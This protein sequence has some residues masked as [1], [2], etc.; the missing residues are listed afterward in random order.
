MDLTEAAKHYGIKQI[1]FH[2][3]G[4]AIG[5]GGGHALNQAILGAASQRPC[6]KGRIKITEQGEMIHS[7]YGNP[8]LAER[9]LELVLSAMIESELLRDPLKLDSEWVKSAEAVSQASYGA[10]RAL[11]YEDPD[12]VTF[13]NQC[14][15]IHEIQDLNI[16]SHARRAVCRGFRPA[17]KTC[18]L[19]RGVFPWTQSRYTLPGW[20]GFGSAVKFG[21][22]AMG[23]GR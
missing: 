10:Y 17:S 1:L 19:S 3:R 13:F 14:T 23:G 18:A 9:N 15:P 2:G 20:Y 5:R 4:G 16:G 21:W 11:V 22:K 8:F 7:K 12:F 6:R